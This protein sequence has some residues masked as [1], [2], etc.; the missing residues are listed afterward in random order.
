MRLIDAD[1]L[2][3]RVMTECNPFGKPT[4]EFESGIKVM[5][6]IEDAPTIDAVPVVHGEWIHT[7][8]QNSYWTEC[9]KCSVCG[10]EDELMFGNGAINYCPNCG[11]RMDG[12]E[13]A[14]DD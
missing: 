2:E 14:N 5:G 12:K 11:A 13:N 3:Y 10:E 7:H 8:T 9:Y 4:L 1:K 6:M